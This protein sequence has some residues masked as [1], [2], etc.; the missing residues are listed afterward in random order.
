MLIGGKTTRKDKLNMSSEELLL[1]L[2]LKH[3]GDWTKMFTSIQKKEDIE[4]VQNEYK[5]SYITLLNERYPNSLKQGYKPPFVLF[6]EGNIDLLNSDNKK[7][8]LSDKRKTTDT[9]KK[10]AEKVLKDL[11]SD[12]V[13]VLGGMTDLAKEI[14]DTHSNPIIVVLPYSID[15][16]KDNELKQQIINNGGVI[17]SEYPNDTP[18]TSDSCVARYRIMASLCDYVLIPTSIRQHSGSYTLALLAL[19]QSKD[20]MVVPTS[21]LEEDNINNEL[22]G[23]GAYPVYDSESLSGIM[24]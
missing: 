24:A 11:S 4:I 6:Y 7:I 3:K 19:Q 15:N 10:V 20:I 22:I 5:G 2:A 18:L 13:L 1:T 8:A 16:F 23:E 14:V 17:I 21:P 12:I 9:D